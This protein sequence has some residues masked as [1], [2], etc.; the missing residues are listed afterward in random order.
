MIAMQN[1]KAAMEQEMQ[2]LVCV[3]VQIKNQLINFAIK[4]VELML[5]KLHLFPQL[6]SQWRLM[7]L[8]RMLIFLKPVTS[9]VYQLETVL[10]RQ[11]K[12]I[13]MDLLAVME[14]RHSYNKPQQ[15][16]QQLQ[17]LH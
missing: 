5:Q 15:Q 3:L 17:R 10:L 6:K 9:S 8:L 16:L 4:I 2:F 1:A 7:G 13:P 11:F 12:W 14:H